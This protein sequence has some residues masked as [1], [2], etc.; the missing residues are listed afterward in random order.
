MPAPGILDHARHA[1][2]T[3]TAVGF[4]EGMDVD[5]DAAAKN[6]AL[7]AILG[8]AEQRGERVRWDRRAHPLDDVAVF[9]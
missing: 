5:T 7:G 8:Q 4:V 9:A 2:G 3:D 6:P 1:L